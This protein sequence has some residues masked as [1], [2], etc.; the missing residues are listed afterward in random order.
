MKIPALSRSLTVPEGIKV[1][2]QGQTIFVKGPL[3]EVSYSFNDTP[4]EF[5]LVGDEL[6]I[7]LRNAKKKEVSLLGTA[8]AHIKNMFIGVTKGYKYRLKMIYAHFPIN[9]KI[10]GNTVKIEN[11]IGERSPRIAQILSGV[12]IKVEDKDI[13]ISGLDKEKVSQSAAN[14]QRATRI[15]HYDPRVFSDGIY[16][17]L[18][19]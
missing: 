4:L 18:K 6:T 3:G 12:D 7:S 1:E 14:I 9:I 15:R 5:S 16:V 17:Y 10:E 11:F 2:I 13:I 19:E 8:E